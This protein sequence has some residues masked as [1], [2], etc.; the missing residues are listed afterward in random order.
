MPPVILSH[1]FEHD[2]HDPW[3]VHFTNEK[4]SGKRSN[5]CIG[6]MA[7]TLVGELAMMREERPHRHGISFWQVSQQG[8]VEPHQSQA[9]MPS[10][11]HGHKNDP[12]Y[13]EK[14]TRSDPIALVVGNNKF[15]FRS[16][17]SPLGVR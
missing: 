2:P 9:S 10:L 12:L 5:F 16:N 17:P 13:M 1:F 8:F 4:L 15:P 7:S 14:F 6:V 3:A 11:R